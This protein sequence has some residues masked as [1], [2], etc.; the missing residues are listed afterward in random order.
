MCLHHYD[1]ATS[2]AL[3]FWFFPDYCSMHPCSPFFTLYCYSRSCRQKRYIY[4]TVSFFLLGCLLTAL[5]LSSL[6]YMMGS[7]LKLGNR[8]LASLLN[9]RV[10]GVGSPGLT[11]VDPICSKDIYMSPLVSCYF[12]YYSLYKC[13]ACFYLS[14]TLGVVLWWYCMLYGALLQKFSNISETMFVPVSETMLLGTM[15]YER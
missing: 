7:L 1:P 2:P 6:S 12:F 15:Y 8:S 5:F 4:K 9:R 10:A 11:G 13:H 3:V 14:I